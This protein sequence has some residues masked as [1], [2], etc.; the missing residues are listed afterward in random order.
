MLPLAHWQVG[1]RDGRQPL[2]C[3]P[4]RP[5]TECAGN[6]KGFRSP[7]RARVLAGSDSDSTQRDRTATRFQV[8]ASHGGCENR[9]P[10]AATGRSDTPRAVRVY[11]TAMHRSESRT[12]RAQ[13]LGC[14]GR[15]PGLPVPPRAAAGFR[16]RLTCRQAAGARP[17]PAGS[18]APPLSLMGP[19][20]AQDLAHLQSLASSRWWSRADT[21]GPKSVC[22][23]P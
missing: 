17:G 6:L 19:P 10:P 16:V 4:Q 11:G 22:Q 18:P 5:H 14:P 7:G 15:Q 2:S 1:D 13:S 9:R 12:S 23:P 20:A 21:G 8:S 3:R